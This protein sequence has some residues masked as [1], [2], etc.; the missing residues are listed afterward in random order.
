MKEKGYTFDAF[1]YCTVMG[2][3]IKRGR[4]DEASEFMENMVRDGIE[5]DMVSYNTLIN[6]YCKKGNLEAAYNLLDEIEKG[7][8]E[9]DKY[10]HTILIDGLCK[11]SNVEGAERHL[12]YMNV[13]GFDSN[14]VAFNCLLDGLCKAGQVDYAM[15]V[16]KSMELKDSFTYSSL[17]HNLCKARRFHSASKLLLSCLRSGVKILRSAQRAVL[18][19]LSSSGYSREASKLRSKIRLAK[20]LQY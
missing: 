16:F 14:L 18:L 11:A 9:C 4:I 15:K 1:A 20:L 3:L 12:R 6:M 10:T 8:F 19:G 7:G 2:A 13:M 5:L 17:V